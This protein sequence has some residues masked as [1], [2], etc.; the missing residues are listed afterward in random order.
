MISQNQ[1][2]PSGWQEIS[3]DQIAGDRKFSI[4][5]GPFGTQLH[6]EE[7]QEE[8]VPVVRIVN[9]SYEGKFLGENIVFISEKKALQLQ[10]SKVVP[11][12]IIIA[13]TGATIGKSGM[14]PDSY[15]SG[16]V[17][18][19]CMKITCDEDKAVP[20]LI[21]YLISWQRGQK[22][23]I[24]GAT[25]STRTT[26]N[27]G[28][29]ANIKFLLPKSI[30]EQ[31]KITEILSTIDEAIEKT[32][33]LIQKYQRIKQ[34]LMQDLLTKGIDEHGNIRDE[35][36]HKFKKSPLGRIPEE[37]E[38]VRLRKLI[39]DHQAGIYKK[40]ELYGSG[41]NIVGVSDLYCVSS[42][43]GQEFQRLP[44]SDYEFRSF[45]LKEGDLIYGES[46]LVLEGIA[47]TLWVTKRGEGTVFAW[48]TRR[49]SINRDLILSPYLYYQ[50]ENH[51]AKRQI[52]SMATQ[53]ALTGI[54]TND[55]LSIYIALPKMTEQ[56]LIT[57]KFLE[58]EKAIT[59]ESNYLSK[60]SRIKT[61]LMGDLL[62]GM[63]RV[64]DLMGENNA[65]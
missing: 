52:M 11:E 62:T 49:L 23:I 1:K 15:K 9:L 3:L 32:E 50:M 33:S 16:I 39:R 41:Y 6:A 38:V 63:V 30:Q 55:F 51:I 56:E 8:G 58:L 18:S 12:D 27:I 36:T 5:D 17:A 20:K 14:F 28:P 25:G 13:K 64:T 19:S 31:S 24:D 44:L 2:I 47:K 29:F 37:W 34:G 54:T 61:G 48:H 4:V 21:L 7:Y 42:I 46:S 26:I 59:Q 57:T 22:K 43:D 65:A 53:T 60:I 45:S 10:R 40:R 35:K